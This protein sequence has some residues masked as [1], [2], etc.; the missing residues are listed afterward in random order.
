ML[1]GGD[2]DFRTPTTP[3]IMNL[4]SATRA[5]A[6]RFGPAFVLSMAPEKFFV[7]VGYQAYGNAAGAYPPVIHG[8][9]DKLTFI[10]VQHYN[11]G[12]YTRG[13]APILRG[14]I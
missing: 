9:R 7:Q 13:T 6:G 5:I 11:T 3:K 14:S 4:I 1:D 2:A 12:T 10:H 8:L